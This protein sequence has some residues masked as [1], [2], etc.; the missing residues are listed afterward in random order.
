MTFIVSNFYFA[1][2]WSFESMA[3]LRFTWR[4]YKMPGFR[5]CVG[6]MCI[7]P[8]ALPLLWIIQIFVFD[9]KGQWTVLGESIPSGLLLLFALD[10]LAFPTT[11]VHEWPRNDE[12]LAS[13]Q[14]RRSLLHLFL[15]GNN[16]FGMKLMDALWTAKHG[17]LSRL[18]RYLADSRQARS[19]LEL[20][21]LEQQAEAEKKA[22]LSRRKAAPGTEDSD[23]P[24]E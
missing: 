4:L 7:G 3:Y 17:D 5:Y 18:E 9:L 13:I 12:Q 10:F 8:V 23:G 1:G 2:I 15:G 22:R 6:L 24:A 16:N 14:F 11:P 19:V 21:C 20:C